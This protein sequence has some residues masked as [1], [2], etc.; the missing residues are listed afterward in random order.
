MQTI[1]IIFL[2]VGLIYLKAALKL[3]ID[4]K[5]FFRKG[6][7]KI[8]N[9]FGLFCYCG[10][11]G[12]GKTYSAI[13]FCIDRKLAT[14]CQII[15]NVQSFKTFSDTVFI[16]DITE[17]ID[18]VIKYCDSLEHDE[19]PNCSIKSKNSNTHS[20]YNNQQWFRYH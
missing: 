17:L 3:S 12:H 15:T 1:I 19:Q 13:K 16:T 4:W 2:L 14:N 7:Q 5:T 11:Q 8:D 6:F 18:Y 20:C 9:Q 10:K